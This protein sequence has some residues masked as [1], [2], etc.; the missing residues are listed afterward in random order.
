MIKTMYVFN[1]ILFT[2]LYM[3]S[4]C[5][6]LFKMYQMSKKYD[7]KID[8]RSTYILSNII[9]AVFLGMFYTIIVMIYLLTLWYVFF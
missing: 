3:S 8:K 1:V 4:A 5:F 6:I 2:V 7:E 9:F